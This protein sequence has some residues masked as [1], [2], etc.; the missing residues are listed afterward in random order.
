[1][2]LGDFVFFII[3]II[4]IVSN[5]V[6]QVRKQKKEPDAKPA[7]TKTGWKKTFEDILKDVRTQ[8]EQSDAPSP[9]EPSRRPSGWEDLILVETEERHL[10]QKQD[11]QPAV[12]MRPKPISEAPGRESDFDELR[13]QGLEVENRDRGTRRAKERDFPRGI[14]RQLSVRPSSARVSD[15]NLS[16]EDLKNAVIW[17]EI[18]SPP[19]GLRE[20]FK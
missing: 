13:G 1:M 12:K 3:F 16:V 20:F 10:P 17:H 8:M 9:M 4:I 6:K 5:I 2:D 15:A 11:Q 7:E 18:L 19:V 14:K